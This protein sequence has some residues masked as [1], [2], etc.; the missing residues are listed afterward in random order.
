V[1]RITR[2]ATISS[3]WTLRLFVHA[4]TMGIWRQVLIFCPTAETIS[5]RF[6]ARRVEAR[7]TPANRGSSFCPN[8]LYDCA[9]YKDMFM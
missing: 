8:R 5:R 1:R 4:I 2:M 6:P 3:Q 7:V 9:N